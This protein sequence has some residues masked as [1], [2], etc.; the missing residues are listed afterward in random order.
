MR[1]NNS[2]VMD[3]DLDNPQNSNPTKIREIQ[4]ISLYEFV[5]IDGNGIY[6]PDDT[7]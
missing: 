5:D 2:Y 6:S 7:A 4:N 3:I 1:H